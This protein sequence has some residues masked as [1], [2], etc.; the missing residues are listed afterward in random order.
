M[1]SPVSS[2]ATTQ[3]TMTTTSTAV[4]LASVPYARA[5]FSFAAGRCALSYERSEAVGS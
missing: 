3:M 1:A 5:V 2:P 4:T